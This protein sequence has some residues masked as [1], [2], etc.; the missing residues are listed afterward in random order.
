MPAVPD[1]KAVRGEW[2]SLLLVAAI[3]A[4]SV[5]PLS[6]VLRLPRSELGDLF[7]NGGLAFVLVGRIVYVAIESPEALTDPLVLIRIQ[8]GI[9]PLIGL[10]AVG[11]VFAWRTRRTE[12][13]A[14]LTWLAAVAAGLSLTVI[15]YDVAC[16]AR[17]GCAGIEAPAPLGFG[18]SGLSETR[19][20]TPLIEAALLLLV[21]GALLASDLRARR[22]LL[23]LASVAALARVA[24]TP[25][26][27]LG[28][29]AIG[30]ETVL[31]AVLGVA[32]LAIAVGDRAAVP[33]PA[34][35]EAP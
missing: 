20:A 34:P 17:D 12:A 13:D 8:G 7:W 2:I 24:F 26:S 29:D 15:S 11:A 21:A 5:R 35:A 6:D 19:M 33:E 25:L 18:M 23:A 3:L 9:E 31:F 22:G 4:M 1:W 16:I 27:V 32:V 14:R 30:L 28:R 10:A